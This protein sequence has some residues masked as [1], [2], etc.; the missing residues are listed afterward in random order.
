MSTYQSLTQQS[1][2][3]C[4]ITN[5]TYFKYINGS[6]CT[7]FA[8]FIQ[9]SFRD[10]L[11]IFIFSSLFIWDYYLLLSFL[12]VYCIIITVFGVTFTYS[13]IHS[14]MQL[15]LSFCIFFGHLCAATIIILLPSLS[16]YVVLLRNKN[17]CEQD[18]CNLH[19]FS[20]NC[21]IST[22]F[23][24]VTNTDNINETKR[25]IIA[26]NY[27][28]IP[29]TDNY[30]Q[31]IGEMLQ[32]W[33]NIV[34]ETIN[35]QSDIGLSQMHWSQIRLTTDIPLYSVILCN[36][37][38]ICNIMV[39]LILFIYKLSLKSE[40]F[41]L[42]TS[43]ILWRVIYIIYELINVIFDIRYGLL[44]WYWYHLLPF[45][46][47]GQYDKYL[48]SMNVHDTVY[49]MLDNIEIIY[50]IMFFSTNDIAL[51]CNVDDDVANIIKQY[52]G[53]TLPMYPSDEDKKSF[54]SLFDC[55]QSASKIHIKKKT[56]CD[57]IK[58]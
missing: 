47:D 21:Y 37:S 10:C 2:Q 32:K 12:I 56:I 8:K 40:Q 14:Y 50:Q 46:L 36:V 57:C 17:C 26:V 44:Y 31:A 52:L 53:K 27:Y 28:L 25:R 5:A 38:F 33:F 45:V 41:P 16:Y 18:T 54:M 23:K 9:P 13:M 6:M 42:T 49:D 39:I 48:S 55:Y 7:W 20:N 1:S 51:I 3:W 34:S 11:R 4:F 58:V 35:N 15:I 30:T 22:L 24:Y 29:L 43:F 19:W